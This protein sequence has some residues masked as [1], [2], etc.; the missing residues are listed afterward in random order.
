MPQKRTV[1]TCFGILILRCETNKMAETISKSSTLVCILVM[2]IYFQEDPRNNMEQKN[3]NSIFN[4]PSNYIDFTGNRNQCALQSL[5]T[6][7]LITACNLKFLRSLCAY[8][9]Y[10]LAYQRYTTSER[11]TIKVIRHCLTL[12]VIVSRSGGHC[13]TE[14]EEISN[15][16]LWLRIFV[17]KD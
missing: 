10:I 11:E 17:N 16:M 5:L 2:A 13:F 8:I 3:I 7:S 9:L 12:K 1:W 6:K 14:S 4:G 15:Y